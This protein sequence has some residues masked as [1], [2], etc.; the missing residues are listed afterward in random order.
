M[1]TMNVTESFLIMPNTL[2]GSNLLP[3]QTNDFSYNEIGNGAEKYVLLPS[4]ASAYHDSKPPLPIFSRTSKKIIMALL[5]PQSGLL[6]FSITARDYTRDKWATGASS[7]LTGC[8]LLISI[9]LATLIFYL[10]KMN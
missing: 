6:T 10:N 1:A 5:K 4:Q 8:S 7:T 2:R 9:A 3:L